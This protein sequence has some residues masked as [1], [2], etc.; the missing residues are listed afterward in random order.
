MSLAHLSISIPDWDSRWLIS[1]FS[2]QQQYNDHHVF[3]LSAFVPEPPKSKPAITPDSLFKIAGQTARISI[4]REDGV[5]GICQ[6]EG[7]VD[8]V[9]PTW[10]SRVCTLQVTGYSKSIQMDCSP[11]FRVFSQRRVSEIAQKIAGSYKLPLSIPNAKGIAEFSVQTQETDY[12]Y[13]CRLAESYDNVFFFDGAQLRFG[14]LEDEKRDKTTLEFGKDVKQVSLTLDVVPLDLRLSGYHL[15]ESAILSQSGGVFSHADKLASSMGQRSLATYPPNNTYLFNLVNGQNDLKTKTAQLL[16]RQ[17][18]NL[19]RLSGVS[20]CPGLKIGSKINITK[21]EEAFTK[22]EYIVI[23]ISHSVNNDRSYSN[24]FAAVPTGYPF[25]PHMQNRSS[26]LCGPLPAIVKDHKDPQNLGRIKVQFIGDEEKSLS[27]WLRVLTPYTGFGGMYFLPEKDDQVV[28]FS[29]DFNIEK[30]P[31]VLPAFYH[32]N[33]PADQWSDPDNKKKGFSTEKTTFKI[34]DRN[35]KLYIE[36][37]EIEIVAR[38]KM[39][40]DGGKMILQQAEVFE[41]KAEKD[42]SI[43]SSNQLTLKGKRIDINP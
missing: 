41:G 35:G 31:F 2:L 22:S 40:L 43:I 32:G 37:D 5:G 42:I 39:K 10:A 8:R 29:E 14:S 19:V 18:H 26:I 38:N 12:R 30:S 20:T 36:A 15:E 33:S 9:V 24:S 6:F 13:L 21:S 16:T 1:S 28:V 25:P 17:A 34:D 3:Q 7:F 4:E 27:P 11:R 23:E